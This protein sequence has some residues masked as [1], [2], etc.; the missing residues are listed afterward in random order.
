M[1]NTNKRTAQKE[2]LNWL[3]LAGGIVVL[4]MLAPNLPTQLLKGYLRHRAKLRARLL[5]LEKR[6]WI[7][8]KQKGDEW[9][10]KLVKD[11]KLIVQKYQT[12]KLKLKKPAKWDG[13]WRIVVFDI[14]EDKKLA[15]EIL[16]DKLKN[17]GFYQLQ[18][19]VFVHPYPCREEIEVIK[20]T[21]EIWAYIRLFEAQ[22]VDAQEKLEEYFEE[23]I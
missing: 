21:Y 16:R 23:L 2:F 13:L 15:R 1:E 10:V 18:K 20:N 5:T 3:L 14:P 12:D 4:S 8:V 22:T 19:S 17:L 6:G 9:E 7:K 11:G